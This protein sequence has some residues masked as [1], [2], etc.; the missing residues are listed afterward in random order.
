MFLV[1]GLG[2]AQG[3]GGSTWAYDPS[4]DEGW[5]WTFSSKGP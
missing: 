5:V 1:E 2:K 3:F 4:E